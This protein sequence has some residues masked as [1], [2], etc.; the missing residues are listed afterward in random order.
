MRFSRLL[1]RP[2]VSLGVLAMIALLPLVGRTADPVKTRPAA[3]AVKLDR[4]GLPNLN[5]VNDNL[6]RAAQPKAE[7][8]Q[9]LEKLGVKTVLNLRSGKDSDKKSSPVRSSNTPTSRWTPAKSTKRTPCN[10]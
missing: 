1:S 2:C 7:G 3:W 10:S 5:K 4:P 6:Y 8:I 9:E